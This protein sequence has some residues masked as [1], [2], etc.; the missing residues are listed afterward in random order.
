MKKRNKIGST[1]LTF[2]TL[3]VIGC[4]GFGILLLN[5]LGISNFKLPFRTPTLFAIFAGCVLMGFFG[6]KDNPF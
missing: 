4:V 3:L 6:Q 1:R 5:H 2:L